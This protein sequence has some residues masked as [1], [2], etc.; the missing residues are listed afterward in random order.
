MPRDNIMKRIYLHLIIA[1]II[2]C[3]YNGV[4][5]ASSSEDTS[6][7][8][9][10]NQDQWYIGP[11]V[12][13]SMFIGFFGIEVQKGH[14]AIT[15]GIPYRLG[16][17]YYFASYGHSPFIGAFYSNYGYDDDDGDDIDVSE[18]GIG[19]GYRWRW[20]DAWEIELNLTAVY[21]E[22]KEEELFYTETEEKI[23]LFPGI[24]FGYSF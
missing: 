4:A 13:V 6:S 22:R 11:R 2:L 19:G 18:G 12:G 7:P 24:T 14:F 15:G 9:D 20:R 5:L 17:K 10:I 23:I 16:A 1:I 21:I 8:D 3:L